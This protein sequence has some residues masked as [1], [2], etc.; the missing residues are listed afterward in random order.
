MEK[1]LLTNEIIAA[2]TEKIRGFLTDNHAGRQNVIRICLAVEEVLLEYQDKLGAET[3]FELMYKKRLG[4]VNV[5]LRIRGENIDPFAN[6]KEDEIPLRFLLTE[7]DYHPAW[8]YQKGCNI[9]RFEAAVEKKNRTLAIMVGSVVLGALLGILARRLPGDT[10]KIICDS[11]LSPVSSTIL[12]LLGTLATILIFVSVVAGICGIGDIS[13]FNRI[14]KRMLLRFLLFMLI[15]VLVCIL[16]CLPVFPLDRSGSVSIDAA[17]LWKMILGIVPTNIIDAFLTGN[18]LQ[19]VFIAIFTG[20]IMLSLESRV[21]NMA[22]WNMMANIIVQKSLQIV[23]KT[24]PLVVFIS[25]F[26]LTANSGLS[27]FAGVYKYPLLMLI[28]S[29]LAMVFF[30]LRTALTQHV[31]AGVLIRKLLPTYVIAITTSSSSAAFATNMETC[32][33]RLGID[34]QIVNIGVPLGQTLFKPPMIFSMICGS[35]CLAELYG[36]P[37]TL[38]KLVTMLL[39]V[40]ILA[41]AAPPVPGVGVSCFTLL[42]AQLGI[43]VE[44]VSIIVALDVLIDRISTST[45]LTL[46]QTELVQL[47]ASLNMLNRETL[48]EK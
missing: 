30:I 40:Y 21:E 17:A 32:E 7:M 39:S 29:F 33:N 25:I 3:P 11:Y 23:I 26:K 46:V 34:K 9:I 44:A 4:Y 12:G 19:V 14:G 16:I 5:I 20:I 38:P 31:S 8:S 47:A 35:F 27:D 1:L 24:M 45:K 15:G 6:A 28:C 41:I 2:S 42:F 43:P 22:D 13:T 10:C 36:V 37:V 18:A 48:R